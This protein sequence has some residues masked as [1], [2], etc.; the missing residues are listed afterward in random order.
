MTNNYLHKDIETTIRKFPNLKLKN[1]HQQVSLEGKIAICKSNGKLITEYKVRI[2]YLA[3]FPFCFP[4]VFEI[5]GRIPHETDRHINIKDGSICLAVRPAERLRCLSGISTY[6]FIETILI[7]HLASQ[8]LFDCGIEKIIRGGY[9]HYIDGI[10]QFYL[11][12]FNT[13]EWNEVEKGFKIV[14]SNSIPNRNDPCY[15]SST[16]KFKNCHITAIET[17]K[18]LGGDYIKTEIELLNQ[19]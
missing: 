19:K 12:L 13:N 6:Y 9:E 7:P 11:E 10:K 14:I 18:N 16:K 1:D 15:C 3:C 8:Y 2:V 4:K 17:L 5:G